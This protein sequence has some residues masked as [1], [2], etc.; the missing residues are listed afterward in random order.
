MEPESADDD[1]S[2]CRTGAG[3]GRLAEEALEPQPA[4]A[5]SAEQRRRR[6]LVEVVL[7]RWPAVTPGAAAGQ[8]R[9]TGWQGQAR[10]GRQHPPRPAFAQRPRWTEQAPEV[11]PVTENQK[12]LVEALRPQTESESHQKRRV[13]R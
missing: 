5:P 9:A 10:R 2:G 13:A 1:C 11:S 4:E 3:Q 12:N 7:E 8:R 6:L